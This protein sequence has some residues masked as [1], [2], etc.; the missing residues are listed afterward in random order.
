MRRILA[1]V[2]LVAVALLFLNDVGRWVNSQ[3]KLNEATAELADWAATNVRISDTAEAARRVSDEGTRRGVKVERYEQD[4]YV[5]RVWTTRDVGGT[6][7]LG[8]YNAVMKG[9]P[10]DQALSVPFV[11]RGYKQSSFQ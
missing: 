9:T 2:L 6:W 4:Q 8:P 1:I 3:S 10:V 7:V 11:V 5:V